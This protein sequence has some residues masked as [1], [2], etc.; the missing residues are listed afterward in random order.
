M[1]TKFDSYQLASRPSNKEQ[2][3]SQID[4]IAYNKLESVECDDKA[5]FTELAFALILVRARRVRAYIA[6]TTTK[7]FARRRAVI[8]GPHAAPVLEPCF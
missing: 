3:N 8:Q 2:E 6:V 4:H 1:L 7:I 5:V